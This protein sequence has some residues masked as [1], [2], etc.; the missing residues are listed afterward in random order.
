MSAV[1]E[2][3]VREFFEA[4]GFFVRQQRKHVSPSR[5][6]EDAVDFYVCNPRATDDGAP[7]FVLGTADLARVARAVVVVKGWHTET[8]SPA[9]MAHAPGMFKFLSPAMFKRA[10]E[11][12]GCRERFLKLLVVPAL[13]QSGEARTKSIEWLR[14]KGIDG[15]L[16]F[17]SMLAF[18]IA[19]T[20]ANRNYVKSDLLQVLRILKSYGLLVEGDQ[21]MDLF[22]K[23]RGR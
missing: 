23:R 5:R 4:H 10:A 18:L 14:A 15:V 7:P 2:A 19:H 17:R 22:G 13:P 6:E 12:F 1:S 3:I 8:F 9:V 20:A 21:Q 11:G 16:P